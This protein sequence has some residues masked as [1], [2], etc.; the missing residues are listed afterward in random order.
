MNPERSQ[1]FW[2]KV[3]KT[4]ACWFWT[5]AVTS[6]GYGS[7][8]VGGKRTQLAHRLAYELL[9]GP[10]PAGLVVDH[11][12]FNKRCVN[13]AH[14]EAVTTAENN[15]RYRRTITHCPHGH[16][17][18]PENTIRSGNK[19]GCRAC[20]NARR[21]LHPVGLGRKIGAAKRWGFPLP[22]QLSA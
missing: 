12:C 20:D 18:T 16:D 1:R 4:P 21:R 10:I 8:G 19:R 3:E 22:Q 9:I 5:A 7:F 14:L 2:A 17:Y 11:T 15:L 6:R 13:P